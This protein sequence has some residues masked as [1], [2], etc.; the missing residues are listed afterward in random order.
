M[1]RKL[2]RSLFSL[3]IAG[4]LLGATGATALADALPQAPLMDEVFALQHT[5]TSSSSTSTAPCTGRP[6]PRPWPAST[7]TG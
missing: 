5:P 2:A 7:W 1:N 4:A 6:T 3:T